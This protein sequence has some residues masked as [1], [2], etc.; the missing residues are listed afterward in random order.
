MDFS[1]HINQTAMSLPSSGIRKFFTIAAAKKDCLSLG[2]GEPD[3]STSL[4]FCQGGIDSILRGDTHYTPNAGLYELRREISRYE[5][6][7]IGVDYDPESEIIVTNG[8]SEGIDVALR[9]LCSAGDEILI[10]EPNFV[11]YAPL[12]KL[13]GATPVC[14]E[15]TS[16]NKFKLTPQLIKDAITAKTKC[17]V[18]SYPNNPTGSIMEKAD[19]ENLTDT[20]NRHDL[21]VISD[22]IYAELIYDEKKFTSIAALPKMRDRTVVISGFSKNFAMTGW[23]LGYV[24]A[25]KE[26]TSVMKTIHQ[27]CAMCAP[28]ISQRVALSALQTSFSNGFAE[29]KTMRN[30]YDV[31]RRFIAEQ[32]GG[33]G[34]DF[35]MPQG[36][37][38]IF[39]NVKNTS[40]TGE[41]FAYTLLDEQNVALI[42]GNAFGKCAKDFVR[43]SFASSLNTLQKAL[44]RISDFLCRHC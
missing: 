20:I 1:K 23:R 16:Q 26:L 40:M 29:L 28:T 44:N 30:T 31:R 33:L 13:C 4:S 3:F 15:T 41:E 18:L 24:C 32:L 25:P 36:T 21:F 5:T 9:T 2:V 42:P 6:H 10:P 8:G 34:F 35:C 14:L 39:P 7:L 38:Y 11:C 17:I 37:F 12:V 27:Y 19:L 43:I 22:E